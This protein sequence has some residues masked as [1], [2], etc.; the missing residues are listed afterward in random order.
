MLTPFECT[1]STSLDSLCLTILG[2]DLCSVQGLDTGDPMKILQGFLAQINTALAPLSPIFT[3][4]DVV[5]ALVDCVKAIPDS[6]GPPPDPTK[7]IQAIGKLLKVL[8]KLLGMLPQMSVPV[9]VKQIL[10]AI[11]TAFLAFERELLAIIHATER[12]AA[13]ATAAAKP[14]NSALDVVVSCAQGRLDARMANLE[15]ATAPINR[16]IGIVN[17]LMDLAQMPK[18]ARPPSFTGFGS[19]A[20]DALVPLAKF[21]QAILDIAKLIPG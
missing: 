2:A 21:A 7:L 8:T 9:M 11:A 12:I 17:L 14:G 5:V 13:A 6:L 3:I 16:L 1:P 20:E 18:D 15:T 10:V 19:S 4:F